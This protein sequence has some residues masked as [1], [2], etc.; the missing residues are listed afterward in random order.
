MAVVLHHSPAV[1]TD[2]IVLLGIANHDGD[3][4]AWP[5]IA[6]LAKYANVTERSV[7]YS[8][9][10]LEQSGQIRR[11]LNA[12]GTRRTRDH[13]RPNWYEVLVRCPLTCDGTIQH[14]MPGDQGYQSR[15]VSPA[16]PERCDELHRGG[17][18]SFTG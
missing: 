8:L 15:G 14:R 9:D 5:S 12:G 10:K 7:Q 11:E 1:G 18:V 17:E 4:G 13:E 2:K 16:T 6:T 3:G